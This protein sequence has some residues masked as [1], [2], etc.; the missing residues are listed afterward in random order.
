MQVGQDCDK[1]KRGR[2]SVTLINKVDP[3]ALSI[4]LAA[5]IALSG[6]RLKIIVKRRYL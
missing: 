5:V 1:V 6:L 2:N 3:V 4:A